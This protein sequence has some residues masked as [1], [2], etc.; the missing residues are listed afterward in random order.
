MEIVD[1]NYLSE[2]TFDA[3]FKKEDFKTEITEPIRTKT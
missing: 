1:H 2:C 3:L